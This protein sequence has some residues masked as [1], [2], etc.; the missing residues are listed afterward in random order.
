MPGEIIATGIE[1]QR[2][3]EALNASSW[4]LAEAVERMGGVASALQAR[5]PA[6]VVESGQSNAGDTSLAVT[7]S[8]RQLERITAVIAITPIGTTSASLQLGDA[9]IELQN[10]TVLLA[11]ISILLTHSAPRLLTW[12]P[13]GIASL[14]LMGEQMA[15][16]G[17]L[18]GARA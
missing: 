3:V 4:H 10:T 12:A 8:T 13:A 11:P 18:D 6:Y 14:V 16:Q 15:D 7:P 9:T 17:F 5:I 2:A 1:I